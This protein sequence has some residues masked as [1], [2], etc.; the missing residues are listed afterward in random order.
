MSAVLSP[1]SAGGW[2]LGAGGSTRCARF[3]VSR[4]P[5]DHLALAYGFK[6]G[7]MTLF[8]Y[9]QPPASSLQ[10]SAALALWLIGF[11]AL[12]TPAAAAQEGAP[13]VV[14]VATAS[15]ARVAPR[16]WAPGD[17]VSRNDARLATSA[18]GRLE[19]VAE[20]GTRVRAGER[21]AKL[22]DE[23]VSLQVEDTK[24]EVAR[25]DAQRAMSARQLERIEQLANNSISQTQIDEVRS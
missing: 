7:C 24:A 16:R 20:V 6:E 10:P 22:E 9:P 19:Y 4:R 11:V 2:G 3:A 15:L 25:I 1:R 12:A 14:E 17:V 23:A 5:N 8:F 18:A 21:V 13:V